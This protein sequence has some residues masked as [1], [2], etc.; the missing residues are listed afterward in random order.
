MYGTHLCNFPTSL[1]L[2]YLNATD[3]D[4]GSAEKTMIM[5]ALT[6]TRHGPKVV[7]FCSA[8]ARQASRSEQIAA[9]DGAGAE[10]SWAKSWLGQ[11]S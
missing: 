10:K 8:V 7:R 6:T 5:G 4:S 1:A 3:G 9:I 11:V 2:M